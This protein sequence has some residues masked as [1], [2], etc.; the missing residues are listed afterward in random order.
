[1]GGRNDDQMTGYAMGFA[2]FAMVLYFAFVIIGVIAGVVS[3]GLTLV[4]L[5]AVVKGKVEF[6]GET[7]TREEGQ[8]F[9]SNGFVGMF[10]L[11]VFLFLVFSALG[12]DL[13]AMRWDLISMIGYALGSIGTEAVLA[14]VEKEKE[15]AAAKLILS[16]PP[17][18]PE[19]APPPSNVI[20]PFASWRDE[21]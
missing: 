20:Y 18:M 3:F 5:T 9:I 4:A 17:V 2:V 19:A 21:D 6:L 7:L 12:F 13:D 8:R 1:M 11:W 15:A 14:E 16:P 10:C